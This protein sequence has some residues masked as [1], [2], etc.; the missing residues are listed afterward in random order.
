MKNLQLTFSFW[1]VDK[2]ED[3]DVQVEQINV[4]VTAILAAATH[5]VERDRQLSPQVGVL[6]L[7]HVRRVFKALS[8]HWF[9]SRHQEFGFGRKLAVIRWRPGLAINSTR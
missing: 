9:R 6:R 5:E 7:D 1:L 4:G 2:I 3:N 8:R